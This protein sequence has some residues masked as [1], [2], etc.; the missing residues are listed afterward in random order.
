MSGIIAGNGRAQGLGIKSMPDIAHDLLRRE[1]VSGLLTPG[2]P[3]KQAHIAKRL[4]LSLAPVREALQR[5][6]SEGLVA[7]RPHRGYVVAAL[8]VAEIED[9]FEMRIWLEGRASHAATSRRTAADV[10][11]LEELVAKMDEC[12]A[13]TPPDLGRWSALNREFHVRLFAISGRQQLCRIA[14]TLLDSVERYV[15]FDYSV[16]E[17]L[18]AAHVEHRQILEAFKARD[19]ARVKQLSQE[20]CRHTRQ[21]LI[22]SLQNQER[23]K[24]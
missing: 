24:G 21:R 6:E 8:D 15:W 23:Q 14:I 5:L 22:E 2:E 9:I 16:G 4:G 13:A 1:I 12:T 3:L 18:K 11:V 17:G 10:E 7:L 20:H 19:A